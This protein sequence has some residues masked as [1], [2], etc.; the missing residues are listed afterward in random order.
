MRER[1]RER[2][3]GRRRRARWSDGKLEE[4]RLG[5][6]VDEDVEGQKGH[7][8]HLFEYIRNKT[9]VS[10]FTFFLN[11]LTTAPPPLSTRPHR[12]RH[13]R[14][15]VFSLSR[16]RTRTVVHCHALP[17]PPRLPGRL[18]EVGDSPTASPRKVPMKSSSI[19]VLRGFFSHFNKSVGCVT[20][21]AHY[22]SHNRSPLSLSS[23]DFNRSVATTTTTND[24]GHTHRSSLLEDLFNRLN[25]STSSAPVSIRAIDTADSDYMDLGSHTVLTIE[26]LVHL[27]HY[28]LAEMHY[29]EGSVLEH[30]IFMPSLLE[31]MIICYCKL[32]K[33]DKANKSM[34]KLLGYESYPCS[35]TYDILLL[36]LCRKKDMTEALCLFTRMVSIGDGIFPSI[37]CYESLI[38]GLCHNRKLD[39]ALQVFDVMIQSR[40]QPTSLIYETLVIHLCKRGQVARAESLC[41]QMEGD[42]G[43]LSSNK[44]VYNYLILQYCKEQKMENAISVIMGMVD[45]GIELDSYT[46]NTLIHGF[47]VVGYVDAVLSS[48]EIMVV[49][50]LCFASQPNERNALQAQ[51]GGAASCNSAT[52][53][54]YHEGAEVREKSISDFFPGW[55]VSYVLIVAHV[56]RVNKVA[57]L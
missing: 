24:D 54:L 38:R 3:R 56:I 13:A 43:A 50:G 49:K 57:M 7:L 36:G 42:F 6:H 22:H 30:N 32:G 37:E 45:K 20:T 11:E 47:H 39:D 10:L 14:R 8:T 9:L 19:L 34:N 28:H 15:S 35:T 21:T 12:N 4:W 48:Y 33:F 27:G 55:V 51:V 29:D 18:A 17:S 2:R 1:E 53:E 5:R 25:S 26:K 40:T 46:Y 41:K 31:S 52:M 44:V 16:A 23:C